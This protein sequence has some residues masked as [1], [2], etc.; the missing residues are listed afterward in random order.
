[1]RV[2]SGKARGTKLNTLEGFDTRPTTDRVKEALF[3]VI[4]EFVPESAVL[5]LF[6]GSGA[7][8]IEALSRGAD[9]AVLIENNPK[10][11]DVIRF[12]LE[13][14]RLNE[15]ALLYNSDAFLFLLETDRQFDIIF[16]DPPYRHKM[17]DKALEII[18]KR[19]I[20]KKDGIV[21]CETSVEEEI[22]TTL[23]VFKQKKYGKTKFTIYKG[24]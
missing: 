12:N 21:I 20:L 10:A 11:S 1:M 18:V 22:S 7:L 24:E 5:D 14:T 3:S 4:A 8:A 2:V 6:S 13:K 15:S 16:L 17:C 19:S 23:T 9:C